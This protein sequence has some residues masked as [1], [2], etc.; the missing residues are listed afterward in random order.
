MRAALNATL[1]AMLLSASPIYATARAATPD[2][3]GH[4]NG[5]ATSAI[6]VQNLGLDFG[7]LPDHSLRGALTADGVNGLALA[8]VRQEGE[9]LRFAFGS[10]SFEGRLDANGKTL[11]GLLSTP[12]GDAS[13]SLTRD[14]EAQFAPTPD[15]ARVEPRMVGVWEGAIDAGGRHLRV[16]LTLA[17]RPDGHG[18]GLFASLDEGLDLPAAI[19]LDG[20]KLILGV[21]TVEGVW[22]GSLDPTGDAL[23]GSYSQ[24]GFTFPLN[25]Q[26][27]KN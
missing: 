27:V 5:M 24:R 20:G 15:N 7:R 9:V 10:N 3:A 12:Q 26:R 1:V 23:V 18:D 2:V 21:P 4:W 16:R 17:N 22:E 13:V 25:L 11:T 19:S 8:S 6:G 14:G